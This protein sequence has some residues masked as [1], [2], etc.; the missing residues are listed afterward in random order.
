MKITRIEDYTRG[1]FV[2]DFEPSSYKTKDFEVGFL[3][4]SKDEIWPKH[5]HKI[6][7]EI[8]L[9]VEGEMILGGKKL[10]KGDV[11]VIEPGE[12][13]DPQFLTECKLVVIK[14]PS[15]PTDKYIL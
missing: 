8:N 15:I 13:A 7:T 6:A 3:T 9:L 1:W 11:F 4:H 5:Y 2:G 14:T 12:V 10:T